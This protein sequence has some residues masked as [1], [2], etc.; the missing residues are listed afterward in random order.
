MRA[1]WI[2]QNGAS[3]LLV[4]FGGWA[5][6]AKPVRHL[7]QECDLLFLDDYRALDWEPVGL[8]DYAE[9]ILLAWSFGVAGYGHWQVGRA[10]MFHRK[11]AVNGTFSP[12]DRR[13]GIPPSIF[14]RTHDGLSVDS[15]QQFLGRTYGTAQPVQQIDVA[16]RQEELAVVE[17]RGA[18]K[19]VLFDRVWLSDQDGVFPPANLNRAWSGQE[20]AIRVLQDAPHAPFDRFERVEALWA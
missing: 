13:A 15:Y 1:Q 6:G 17:Q 5:V 20:Q 7:G 19:E 14:R 4:V 16:A 3:R 10:D 2:S 9:R 11:I 8:G 18:C 12:V